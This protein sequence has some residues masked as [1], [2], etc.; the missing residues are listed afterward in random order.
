MYAP[1]CKLFKKLIIALEFFGK[2]NSFKLPIITVK[3]FLNHKLNNFLVYINFDDIFQFFGF[4]DNFYAMQYHL[5]EIVIDSNNIF[6]WQK[7][8]DTNEKRL[9][10]KFQLIPIFH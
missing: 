2:P 1:Y 7:L 3:M 10:S 9:F 6:F 4:L 5:K 8:E